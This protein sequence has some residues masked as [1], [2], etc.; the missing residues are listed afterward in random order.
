MCNDPELDFVVK[1]QIKSK[2]SKII[3]DWMLN[4]DQLSQWYLEKNGQQVL[5]ILK[6]NVVLYILFLVIFWCKRD[7]IIHL[8]YSNGDYNQIIKINKT[9]K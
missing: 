7:V 6:T 9:Y 8:I 2:D 1:C 3:F 4:R 5:Y